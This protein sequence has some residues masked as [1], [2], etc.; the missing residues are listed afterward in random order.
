[1]NTTTEVLYCYTV[2]VLKDGAW[3]DY[4]RC[5]TAEDALQRAQGFANLGMTVHVQVQKGLQ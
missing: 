5:S 3:V 1:M 2:L 4:Y